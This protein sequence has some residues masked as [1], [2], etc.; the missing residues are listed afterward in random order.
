MTPN[1]RGSWV[2]RVFAGLILIAAGLIWLLDNLGYQIPWDVVLPIGLI[3]VGFAL[4]AGSRQGTHG[5]LVAI[6]II[7]TVILTFGITARPIFGVSVIGSGV[8]ERVE[9]PSD[10]V[11]LEESYRL[12]IGSLEIDLSDLDLPEGETTLDADVG[13]GE[14][15]VIVPSDVTVDFTGRAGI[16]EVRAFGEQQEGVGPSLSGVY[17]RSDS[18]SVLVLNVRVGVGKV[19]VER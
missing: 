15:T 11:E 13:M 17:T 16:G 2:G 5:G 1:S 6:G 8:G 7:L 19:E 12:G 18:E 9:T 4:V 10:T 14:I 3:V